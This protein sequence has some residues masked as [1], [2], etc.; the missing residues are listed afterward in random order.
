MEGDD[1]DAYREL[2]ERSAD[3]ILIIEGETFT[4][5]NQATVDMLRYANKADLLSTH[6]SE[7]SPPTQPDGRDSYT[8]A[9]EMIAI[10][11][12]RGSHRFDWEHKRATGEVFPV[13]VLLTAVPGESR[14]VLHVVW[15]DIT[16]RKQLESHLRHAQ[17]MEAIGK[18]AG[19]IAHDFNN[20][21]VAIVCSGSV[22]ERRLADRP[23]DLGFVKEIL[24][25]GDR[26]STL[27]RQLLTFSRKQEVRPTVIDI[28]ELVG[29]IRQLLE[30]LI[31]EQ[32][33]IALEPCHDQLMIRA[34]PGQLEQ[35]LMNLASNARDAMP[36][37]GTLTIATHRRH[38]ASAPPAARDP[39]PP[40]DY[41]Q[42]SVADVGTGMSA[43][44]LARAFDPFF[45]TKE[46]GS[47]TGLGLAT[48][49]GIVQQSRG[50]IAIE[51]VV[52]R[53]TKID[54]YLP[55]TEESAT[56]RL[57]TDSD[58]PT[59]GGDERVLVV[60]DDPRVADVVVTVL[61][62]KGYD[63]LLA[64]NGREALA[65]WLREGD[66]IDLAVSDVVM[67]KMGGPEWV[68]EAREAGHT[69]KVLFMSGYTDNALIKLRET[70][71]EA[72]L[73]EKPFSADQ[74]V[75]RVRLA[76]DRE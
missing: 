6:P 74:L 8:K 21:L 24:L 41:A 50:T 9:N 19:G 16:E 33:G 46:V 75:G 45:T 29:T 37:G 36:D 5:C 49:Y 66:R 71:F 20:L 48:V 60:E 67:P 38:L 26:A 27:V 18:L 31:G 4:D 54:I 22:L 61:D 43:A 30:R 14:R 12:D 47:G 59:N 52:G 56:Q 51:S 11:F 65:T 76:L 28:N 2:F 13:E 1:V 53:G 55:I 69:P 70:G 3:A 10:A 39:L 57:T 62:E 58:L 15:R 72:D 23:E 35:V 25:A 44:T 68:S 17:K 32:I 64:T 42:L 40:G 7:L 73:L 63:V 34:D